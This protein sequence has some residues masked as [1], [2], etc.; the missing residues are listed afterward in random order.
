MDTR[1][2]FIKK[3]ALLSG[4]GM[5]TALHGSIER[6][7][8]IAPDPGSTF[9]DAEHVVI[10]MQ[11]NRSF[12]H[13]F[14]TLRGVRGLNDPRAIRLPNG[15][16]VWIQTND[17][18]AS[19]APF[20]LNIKDTNATWMGSLPHSWTDQVDAR[21]GGRCDRWLQAKAS[22]HDAYRDMPL[23]MGHYNRDDIPFY[24]AL[25]DAFTVCDYNFCSSLT[26]TTPNRLHLWT[27]TV[28]AEQKPQAWPNVLNSDVEYDSE[29]SWK[30]YP[31]RLEEQGISWKIYQ[32][33]LSLAT[34]LRGEAE[35]WLANFTDNP[36]EWFT[37]YG[38]RYSAAH[39]QFLQQYAE[40]LRG[41]VKT[42]LKRQKEA[43]LA[44]EE[45][46]R[47]DDARKRLAGVE[48]ERKKWSAEKFNRLAPQEQALHRRAFTTNSGDPDYH[49]LATLDYDDE[50]T[51]R[52][53]EV[54]KG[55]VLHQFRADVDSGKLPTVSWLVAPERFSD[56]PGSAWY[57]AWYLAET[58]E[59]LT[60][61]PEI[62]KKTVFILTYDE[63]DGYFDHIPPFVPPHPTEPD[64]GKVSEGID[65]A[66]EYVTREQELT[67][68]SPEDARESPIGLGYRVPM[69]IASPWSR[70]GAVCSE[71]FDH[72]S[73][74][75]FL[76]RL[77]EHRTGKPVTETNISQ[78]RRTVCGDLTS[79]FRPAP[80]EGDVSLP[81]PDRDAFLE[82]IHRAQF[83]SPPADF[84]ALTAEEVEEVR[85]S[86]RDSSLLI[87]QESGH[88]PAAPLPYELAVDGR[89]DAERKQ[90]ELTFAA[91]SKR[92]GAESLG[93]PFVAYARVGDD[94]R[95]RNYA[96]KAGDALAD[97]WTIDEFPE[98]RYDLEAYGPNGFYRRF[99]GEG[100]ETPIEVTL[101]EPTISPSS[102]RAAGH[103]EL[104]LQN[105]GHRPMVATVIDNAYGA[106]PIERRLAAGETI[107]VSIDLTSSERWY[108]L[109]VLVDGVQMF[110]RRYAGRVETGE[111]GSSDPAL[112][113]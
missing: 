56:H 73:V 96:V 108:D 46:Q 95:I 63:N 30:T 61:R 13:A 50:G 51:G 99:R 107:R 69:I 83:K 84:R 55:D 88:R 110:E 86:P 71:V 37:Q 65:V 16:P 106:A 70:G 103:V 12:D 113:V 6:A 58:L 44:E 33:E 24:Y 26:G 59:I 31:E 102:R 8:A 98:G 29:A 38:V 97:V 25:A 39:Q 77:L 112:S 80:K 87:K 81:Y 43:N 105:A 32:N 42:L 9:L 22:G 72:T 15:N 45:L 93:A 79:A 19:Y 40:Q 62:W 74:L 35:A 64:S 36:I 23:T 47:L 109:S 92:F 5:W 60:R 1:R 14:G 82:G 53:M 3:A 90:L 85:Q 57:G 49:D 7:M 100:V 94:L 20:R 89:V 66:V 78:W 68:K 10:L 11:E 101:K 4:A 34:G 18:G 2:D 91:G 27:G 28:R 76:E 48:S 52:T 111:W 54:P 104:E 21:R 17:A 75:Q 41:E 67:R